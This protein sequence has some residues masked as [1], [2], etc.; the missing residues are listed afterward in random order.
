MSDKTIKFEIVTP[1][2]VVFRMEVK[3]VTVPT[4]QG[5]ITVLPEHIPLVSNLLPGVIELVT[6]DGNIEIISVSGGFL[7]VLK[8]K[9]VIL[10]DTAERAEEIDLKRAEEARARA[11]KTKTE[12]K[13]AEDVSYTGSAAQLAKELARIKAVRRHKAR[14]GPHVE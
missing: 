9:V 10:A 1:E 13:H 7:E 3:Q 4:A 11:E 5:E 8:N 14:K 2:R 12:A 6:V